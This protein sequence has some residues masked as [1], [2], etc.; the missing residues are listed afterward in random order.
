VLP[1]RIDVRT[2]ADGFP[3]V[4]VTCD[5]APPQVAAAVA[6]LRAARDLQFRNAEMTADDVVA[7]REMTALLDGLDHVSGAEGLV[8]VEFS[9]ARLGMLRAALADAPEP[10]PV[11]YELLDTLDAIHAE[12]IEAAV[13]GSSAGSPS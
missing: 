8:P 1:H 12:A 5:L 9:V 11:G 13:S 10:G 4:Q 7:M 3:I 2:D 6:A